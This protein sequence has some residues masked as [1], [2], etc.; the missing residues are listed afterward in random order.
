MRRDS[1]RRGLRATVAT[2][3]VLALATAASTQA[4]IPSPPTIGGGYRR[5]SLRS[6]SNRR[7][8]R[9]KP[10]TWSSSNTTGSRTTAG[11]S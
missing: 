8:G 7:T 1:V 10:K 11:S 6:R 5:S 3:G 4:P 9:F 2:A